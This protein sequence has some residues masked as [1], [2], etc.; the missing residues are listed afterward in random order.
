MRR[1]RVRGVAEQR[2][3]ALDVGRQWSVQVQQIRPERRRGRAQRPTAPPPGTPAGRD[4]LRAAV[5]TLL[6]A[7]T[8]A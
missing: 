5:R 8:G 3:P 7:F 4:D 6:R 1:H 2:D